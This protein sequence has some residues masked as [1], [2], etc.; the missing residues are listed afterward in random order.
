MGFEPQW[1]SHGLLQSFVL[2]LKK[3]SLSISDKG[4]KKDIKARN[5]EK[6]ASEPD[7][8]KNV[9]YLG[10]FENPRARHRRPRGR[11]SAA[12]GELD[13]DV[14]FEGGEGDIE[15]INEENNEF[16]VNQA[17]LAQPP[18]PPFS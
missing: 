5:E 3:L 6:F 9:R 11:T 17:V 14:E 1:E 4:D 16:Q 15:P 13:L 12:N 7:L 18:L 8:K 10:L 2:R